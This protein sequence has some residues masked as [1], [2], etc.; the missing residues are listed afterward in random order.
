[1]GVVY[2]ARQCVPECEIALRIIRIDW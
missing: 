1:M 2:L